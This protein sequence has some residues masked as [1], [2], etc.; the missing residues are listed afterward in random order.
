MIFREPHCTIETCQI[1]ASLE[2]IEKG[3][4]VSN[5]GKLSLVECHELNVI[6]DFSPMKDQ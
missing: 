3:L 4:Q 2:F 1:E 5:R 6:P